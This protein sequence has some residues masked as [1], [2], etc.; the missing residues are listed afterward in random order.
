[1]RTKAWLVSLL[2]VGVIGALTG[3]TGAAQRDADDQI[4]GAGKV[5]AF[6]MRV[7][8]C[9]ITAKLSDEILEVPGLPCSQPHDGEVVHIFALS[10]GDYDETAIMAKA[11]PTCA[12]A[13][14]DYVGG[15]YKPLGIDSWYFYP[16]PQA[17]S[18]GSR[19]VICY[20]ATTSGENDLSASVKRTE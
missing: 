16:D 1:M 18:N 7:G 19:D 12:K 11:D 15:D 14:E 13:T 9:F 20:I 8:D 6:E 17:W 5:D 10:D 3:C 2:A 4:T